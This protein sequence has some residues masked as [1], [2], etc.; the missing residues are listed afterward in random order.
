MERA[1]KPLLVCQGNADAGVGHRKS[2]FDLGGVLL[3]EGYPQ[4]DLPGL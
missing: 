2:D 3:L 1:E 4:Q